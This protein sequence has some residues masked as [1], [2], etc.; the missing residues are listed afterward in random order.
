MA[1]DR[2]L[3]TNDQKERLSMVYVLA[4]AARAGYTTAVDDLD[5]DGVDLRIQAGGDMRP[6]LDLQLKATVN[7]RQAD[8][9]SFRFLLP[10][11]NYERLRIDTLTPRLLV[12]LDLPRD[13]QQ[14][15]TVTEDELI[16]RH[17]AYWLNLRGWEET[18][19][20]RR[21]TVAIPKENIFDVAG[22]QDLMERSRTGVIL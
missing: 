22:L 16:I 5:R 10:V 20:R 6:A 19:N 11:G 1:T 7:L 21:I 3:T 13:E 8:S 17:R 18:D 4:I 15:L 9:E 2:L 12:V 14:W